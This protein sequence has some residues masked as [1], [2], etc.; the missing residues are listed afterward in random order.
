MSYTS[1][2]ILY[3]KFCVN[4]SLL[5][6][7]INEKNKTYLHSKTSQ[8]IIKEISKFCKE[9][10]KPYII[11]DVRSFVNDTMK[12]DIPLMLLLEILKIT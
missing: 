12:I 9:C 5:L 3:F 11:K 10:R 7:R 4:F 8:K 2:G 1:T 6:A